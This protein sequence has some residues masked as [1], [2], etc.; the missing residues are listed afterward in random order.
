M[1]N[2]CL[3]ATTTTSTSTSTVARFTTAVRSTT[4]T[5]STRV[6]MRS[7]TRSTRWQDLQWWRWIDDQ[8]YSEAICKE[9]E[10]PR[11]RRRSSARRRMRRWRREAGGGE[12]TREG[13]GDRDGASWR[14]ICLGSDQ[15][16]NR[17]GFIFSTQNNNWTRSTIT[18]ITA[19][20]GPG[21]A[22]SVSGQNRFYRV[23]CSP[24]K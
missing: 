2:N 21:R 13:G 5:R 3:S 11:G 14:L 7:A 8:I 20:N 6:A 17:L 15:T 16:Y 12:K 9:E 19:Q 10:D 23:F 24:H 18:P 1:Y 4:A 22:E